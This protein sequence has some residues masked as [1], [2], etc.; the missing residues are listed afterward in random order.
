MTTDLRGCLHTTL[1]FPLLALIFCLGAGPVP[2]WA[3]GSKPILTVDT[4]GHKGI[5]NDLIV[6]P[7]NRYLISASDDKTIRVWDIRTKKEVRKILGQVGP[8]NEGKIF[9]IALSPDGR[10]LAAGGYFLPDDAIRIYNFETGALH[11]VLKGH[12]NV[13]YD[14]AFS[15]DGTLLVSGSADKSVKL[16]QVNNHF[17]LKETLTGHKNDVYAVAVLEDNTIVSAGYDEQVIMWKKGK[18]VNAYRHSHDLKYI[19]I[20]NKW[21]AVSGNRN[22]DKKILIFDH[23]LK[24]HKAITSPTTP[25]GLA[26][27]RDGRQL[28]AGTGSSPYVSIIYDAEQGFTE[29]SRFQG[30]DNLVMAVA[31]LSDNTA[32]T[33]GGANNDIFFWKQG[34]KLG[35]ISGAGKRIWA[36][37]LDN[38]GLH[39]GT[40]WKTSVK[41]HANPLT[42]RFD[43]TSFTLGNSG[44]TPARI[45]TT[46]GAWTLSHSGGGDYGYADATLVI[47]KNG[48]EQARITRDSTDGLGH[49]AYGF[50]P[51]GTIVSGGSNGFLATY[52]KKGNKLA[53]FMGHTGEIWSIAVLGD[54]LLS[55]GDDQTLMLWDLGA[56]KRG[57]KEIYPILSLFAGDDGE[58]VAWSKSGYYT[59]SASGDKY[60][61]FH[62]NGGPEHEA[63]FYP[64]SR[65]QASLYRPDIIKALIET[66]NE[67]EAVALAARSRKT[68]KVEAADILPPLIELVRPDTTRKE[69][70]GDYFDLECIVKPQSAHPVTEI[71]ILVNGRPEADTRSIAIKNTGREIRVNRRLELPLA[72]N[73]ITVFARTA[74]SSSN[75]LVLEINRKTQAQDI[76]KPSL[77]MLSVGVSQYADPSYN[78]AFADAD[79]R[80][81]AALFKKQEGRLYREVKT[82]V[83]TNEEADRGAILDGLDWLKDET[84]QRDVAVIFIAG[85]GLNEDT[86]YY[87]LCHDADAQRLR[88]TAVNWRDFKD[89]VAGLPSKVFLLADTCHSGAIIGGGRR[90]VDNSM[91]TAVKELLAAGTGQVIMTAATGASYSMEDATWGHGAFTKAILE[92]LGHTGKAAADFDRNHIVTIKEIDLYVTQRVKELTR[93]KQKPTTIV[94]ESVPDF[95]V[96]AGL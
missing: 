58:W 67:E 42:Q 55:G 45:S 3:D 66:G 47:S 15:P 82:R 37:G 19:A 85:H 56:L 38:S 1:L 59:S 12:T 89:I 68:Q 40:T 80:D 50:L 39:W 41:K 22:D 8:G 10:W 91:T 17:S 16:W 70:P 5:I 28:V 36:V 44:G 49:N 84:T 48:Q 86:S 63:Q 57:E 7:D 94:P 71:Q 78:L 30:H 52:D 61:G 32:V 64:A 26:F 33:A 65:F 87:F 96:A 13:V 35:Q 18:K 31:F 14:L 21:I 51:E 43:L 20:S 62:V 88:R 9:A 6:T 74:Y 92:G 11:Q 79:A 34:K 93:G 54:R 69:V 75:P 46:S 2:V 95:A 73:I 27:S 23:Q 24:L 77:Y 60:V 29:L 53:Q 83:L 76:F 72:R 4:G 25:N 90:G 81:T